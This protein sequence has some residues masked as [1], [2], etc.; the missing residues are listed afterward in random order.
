MHFTELLGLDH[1]P[2]QLLSSGFERLMKCYICLGYFEKNKN[3]PDSKY[4]KNCGGKNGHDLLILK[5]KIA[6]TF[7]STQN[8]DILV[9]D[10]EFLINDEYLFDLLYMLSEFGKYARYYNLDVVTSAINPSIDVKSL[11]NEFE[12]KIAKSNEKYA[13]NLLSIEIGDELNDFI[14]RTIIIILEKFSRAICRQFTMGQLGKKAKQFSPI[15]FHFIT[16]DDSELGNCDYRKKTSGYEVKSRKLHRR[17]MLDYINRKINISY[18]SKMIKKG[19]FDQEWP[20]RHDVVT[21]ECR[22]KYWCVVSIRG[23]DY[24][25]NG[26]AKSR[27]KLDDVHEAGMAIMGISVQPFIKMASKLGGS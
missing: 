5:E 15:Y 4:L 6:N 16:M 24:A 8:N 7:F 11:W 10:L 1:L 19:D 20:F 14:N 27:Y 18:K 13:K 9:D 3:Y 25:L 23:F 22:H 21:I 17:T 12:L 2:M 26:A